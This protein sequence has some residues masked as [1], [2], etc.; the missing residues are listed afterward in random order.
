MP[1][2]MDPVSRRTTPGEV[3]T[4]EPAS[5]QKDGSRKRLTRGCY[6]TSRMSKTTSKQLLS[7]RKPTVGATLQPRRWPPQLPKKN[8]QYFVLSS[9]APSS[10]PP[11]TQLR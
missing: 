1:N 4:P 9:T 2:L 11:R 5:G 6:L 7:C 8:R 10:T 3:K